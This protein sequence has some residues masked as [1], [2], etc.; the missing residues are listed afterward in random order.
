MSMTF[1]CTFTLSKCTL[2]LLN[3]RSRLVSAMRHEVALGYVVDVDIRK[4]SSSLGLRTVVESQYPLSLV[5][6]TIEGCLDKMEAYLDEEVSEEV[7]EAGKRAVVAQRQ[8]ERARMKEAGWEVW[9]EILQQTYHFYRY[10]YIYAQSTCNQKLNL[11]VSLP[12]KM[13]SWMSSPD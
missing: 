2:N 10:F 3:L 9:K 5:H 1:M 7:L 11:I 4:N 12:D 13:W 6:D 8:E